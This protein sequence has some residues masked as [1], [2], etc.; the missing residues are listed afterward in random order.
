MEI[1]DNFCFACSPKNPIGLKLQFS[2]S[3]GSAITSWTPKKEFQGFPGILHGGIIATILDEVMAYAII[4]KKVY[5]PTVEMSIRFQKKIP[6][7]Q[8]L[9]AKGW[10]ENEQK[11]IIFVKGEIRNKNGEI[12]ANANGKYFVIEELKSIK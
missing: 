10:I 8:E 4:P 6:I 2:Y 12:L 3:D 1:K 9:F 7:G 11:N 5:A